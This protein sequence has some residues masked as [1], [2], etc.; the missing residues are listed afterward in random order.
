MFLV[1]KNI[2]HERRLSRTTL[3]DKHTD[4]V[5]ANFARVEAPE[6]QLAHPDLGV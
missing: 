3:P 6:L 5:I 4:F 1:P 2:S